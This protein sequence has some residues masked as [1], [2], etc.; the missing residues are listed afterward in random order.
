MADERDKLFYILGMGT[1]FGFMVALTLAGLLVLGVY[2]DRA[3]D[4]K[5]MFTILGVVLGLAGTGAEIRYVVLPFLEK[6]DKL[7]KQTKG[8]IKQ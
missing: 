4:T 5:P 8:Q 7:D 2:L 3:L 6:K 1:Q